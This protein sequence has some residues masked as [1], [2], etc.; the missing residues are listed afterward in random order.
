MKNKI[1][2]SL[3]VLIFLTVSSFGFNVSDYESLSSIK[4]DCDEYKGYVQIDLPNEINNFDNLKMYIEDNKYYFQKSSIKDYFILNKNWYTSRIENINVEDMSKM[5]DNNYNSYVTFDNESEIEIVFNNPNLQKFDKIEINLMDSSI[6][7]ILVFDDVENLIQNNYIQNN[8][9]YIINLDSE[10]T[11]NNFKLNIKF[12]DI[13][14]ITEV[15]IFE[16]K[17]EMT[18]AKLYLYNDNECDKNYKLYFGNYGIDNSKI[19]S[20]LEIP[21][22]IEYDILTAKNQLYNDDF[23]FDGILNDIDNCRNTVNE[24]QK[25]INYNKIGDA[26]EDDDRDRILNINDNCIDKYNP[27]QV[28]FDNDLIGD[29]CDM[30]DN[31][32]LESHQYLKYIII[33]VAVIAFSF[34]SYMLIKD[35]KIDAKK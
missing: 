33:F 1:F 9:K 15:V 31:R 20:N 13:L 30:N 17:Q 29:A 5:T 19:Y 7:E 11:S 10:E 28:D 21:H 12:K 35:D 22:K 4:L 18:S 25:D 2:L 16:K 24:D 27:N 32:V 6:D 26:C 34:I 23:D 14:K 3:I 8:F